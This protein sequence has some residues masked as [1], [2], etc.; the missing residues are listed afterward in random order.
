LSGVLVVA[1]AFIV[2]VDVLSMFLDFYI[3][4][5]SQAFMYQAKLVNE[6]YEV[7]KG[8]W[9]ALDQILKFLTRPVPD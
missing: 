2:E 5:F 6:S 7:I 9:V 1:V 4:I 8:S 3:N